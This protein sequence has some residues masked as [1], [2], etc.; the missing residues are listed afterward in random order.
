MDA[1][2]EEDS[3]GA[4]FSTSRMTELRVAIAL[5]STRGQASVPPW[6]DQ[7]HW[8]TLAGRSNTT[9]E[10]KTET[11][12]DGSRESKWEGE[13]RASKE[14]FWSW[15]EKDGGRGLRS[16]WGKDKV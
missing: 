2:D 1:E 13:L 7:V 11:A 16:T 4:L 5:G 15:R 12:V 14:H 3:A 6:S 9:S 10:S 8:T